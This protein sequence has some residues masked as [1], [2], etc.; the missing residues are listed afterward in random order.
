MGIIHMRGIK[1][2][3]EGIGGVIRLEGTIYSI[4][5]V[6]WLLF[7]WC[8]F[9]SPVFPSSVCLLSCVKF[10]L[11]SLSLL[12]CSSFLAVYL[13]F[14]R[15]HSPGLLFFFLPPSH[16]LTLFSSLMS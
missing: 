9:D 10:G 11:S 7:A 12:Y 16:Y 14:L 13:V 1:G 15:Y 2:K 4:W 3:E 5:F 6:S 8:F